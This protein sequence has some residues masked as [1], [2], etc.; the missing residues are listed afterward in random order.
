ITFAHSQW[1]IVC[2]CSSFLIKRN[3]QIHRLKAYNSLHCNELIHRK[4][5]GME[6]APKTATSYEKITIS[7]H[8]CATISSIHHIIHKNDYNNDWHTVA[9]CRKQPL[10]NLEHFPHLYTDYLELTNI[11]KSKRKIYRYKLFTA[12]ISSNI[13][14]SYTFFF[15]AFYGRGL[16]AS[17]LHTGVVCSTQDIDQMRAPKMPS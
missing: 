13:S 11:F 1:M 16:W 15:N 10:Q 6:P 14:S 17:L 3:K 4:T 5:V 9:L 7:K 2:N 12:L 8:T